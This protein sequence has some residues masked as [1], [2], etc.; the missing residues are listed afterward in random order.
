LVLLTLGFAAMFIVD[1][2]LSTAPHW[3][4]SLRLPLSVGAIVAL[5]MGL[6]I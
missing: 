1:L 3:Y 4:R 2:Q 6:L 5:L